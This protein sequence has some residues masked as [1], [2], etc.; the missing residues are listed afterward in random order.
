M[1]RW[2]A[3]TTATCSA[4]A[5]SV[6]QIDDGPIHQPRLALGDRARLVKRDRLQLARLFEVDAAL[7]RMPRRAA[8]MCR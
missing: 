6:F 3:S 8:A 5:A 4:C 7:T 1:V 2:L